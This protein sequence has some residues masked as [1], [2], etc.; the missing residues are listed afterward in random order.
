MSFHPVVALVFALV[1]Q[2]VAI[3]TTPHPTMIPKGTRIAC[4]LGV[5]IDSSKAQVGDTFVLY[6]DDPTHASLR[7]T[8]IDGYIDTVSNGR[9]G[10]WFNQITFQN[11][12]TE[13]IHAYVV[14]ARVVQ[15]QQQPNTPPPMF[16]PNN[17]G[18]GP[19]PSTIAFQMRIGP[20]PST[21][22]TS[23]AMTGGYVYVSQSKPIVVAQGTPVT[24]ELATNLPTP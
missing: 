18:M 21:A 12:K 9:I 22:A 13:P 16:M 6:P 2:M 8:E 19:S 3:T 5:S 23:S 10:F 14:S 11:G 20:K 15:R 1:S 24:I 17:S 4:T 7:G